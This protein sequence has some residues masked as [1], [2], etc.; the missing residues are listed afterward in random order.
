MARTRFFKVKVIT[1]R[2]KVKSRSHYDEAQLHPPTNVPTKYQHPT[3][4][5]YWDLALTR[6]LPTPARPTARPPSRTP[7]VKTIP[8]SLLRLWG[9]KEWSQED[10]VLSERWMTLSRQWR[11]IFNLVFHSGKVMFVV[12]Y[13][14]I[15]VCTISPVT[16]TIVSLQLLVWINMDKQYLV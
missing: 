4:Y 12:I 9:K 16:P 10:K 11:I 14:W 7:W 5:C 8:Q 13:I 1:A 6:Y 2:L 15:L 3:P